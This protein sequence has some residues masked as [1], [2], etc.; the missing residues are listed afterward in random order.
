MASGIETITDRSMFKNI[1]DRFFFNKTSFVYSQN[2]NIEVKFINTADGLVK[3]QMPLFTGEPKNCIAFTRNGKNVIFVFL[4]LCEQKTKDIFVFN[5][6][7]FQVVTAARKDTRKS[8]VN[9]GRDDHIVYVTNLISDKNIQKF[10]AGQENKLKRNKEIIEYDNYKDFEYLKIFFCS[11]SID[12]ARMKYF[13]GNRSA[14]FIRDFLSGNE[15]DKPFLYYKNFIHKADPFLKKH[16][17][18]ISE[19]SAPILLGSKIPYGYIQVNKTSPFQSSVVIRVQ[20]MAFQANEINKKNNLFPESADKLL[21]SDVSEKGIGVVFKNQKFLQY[22]K[23]D[24]RVSFDMLLPKEIK[25]SMLADVRHLEMMQNKI[26]KLGFEIKDMDNISR[27]HYQKFLS[28][29]PA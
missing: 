18:Y 13:Y 12:D 17:E 1:L 26:I 19:I 16:N 14:F 5:P 28:S 7:K 6:A 25:A 10:L 3:I 8:L 2:G 21:V 11:E 24:N 4:K 15:D 27:D 22:Y 20:K 23:K 9:N 29:I